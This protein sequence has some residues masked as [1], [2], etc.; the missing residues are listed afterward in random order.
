MA[1]RRV[2]PR[3]VALLSILAVVATLAFRY[4]RECEPMPKD[5]SLILKA[6]DLA[7]QGFNPYEYREGV[8]G[9]KYSPAVLVLLKALPQDPCRA[10]TVFASLSLLLWGA[11]LFLGATYR[12]YKEVFLL[13]LGLILSW[14]GILETLDYGQIE[15]LIFGSVCLGALAVR[16]NIMLAGMLL[17]LLPWIKA[18]WIFLGLPFLMTSIVQ[19][20]KRLGQFTSGLLFSFFLFGAAIPS[21]VFGSDLAYLLSKEWVRTLSQQPAELFVD[22]HNQGILASFYR[23]SQF[24]PGS[25]VWVSGLTM[26]LG[27]VLLGRLLLFKSVSGLS[28]RPLAWLGPWLVL[29]Q[30]LNPLSWR[31]ASVFMVAIPFAADSWIHPKTRFL[32]WIEYGLWG[33]IAVLFLLQQNPVVQFLGYDHWTS[34]HSSGLITAYWIVGILLCLF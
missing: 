30:L 4:F 2:S 19:G 16:K 18:P 24:F 12:T 33:L 15:I 21:L 17:G 26:I 25:E 3:I 8:H 20:K 5:F 29:T 34:L 10:W 28:E 27:G 1:F 22:D 7:F 31:W 13:F 9:Y 6:R 32:K 14:K 11:A 23:I